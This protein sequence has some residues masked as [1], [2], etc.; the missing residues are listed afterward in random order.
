M[1][2]EQVDI[3]YNQSKLIWKLLKTDTEMNE[4]LRK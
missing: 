3:K 2:L 4:L 1:L